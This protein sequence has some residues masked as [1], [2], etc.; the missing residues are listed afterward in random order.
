MKHFTLATAVVAVMAAASTVLVGQPQA[1]AQSS[2]VS[3]IEAID[4][5]AGRSKVVSTPGQLERVA[6]S[7]P[8]IADLKVVN[9]RQILLQ[10]LSPGTTT[11]MVWTKQGQAKSYDVTVGLDARSVERQVR[12]LTGNSHLNVIHNGSAY[13]ISGD[14]EQ[15]AQRDLA[16]KIVA[17]YGAPVVNLVQLPQRREQIQ[18]DV[19]VVELSKAAARDAN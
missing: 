17:S 2:A 9:G 6:I 8:K 11:L 4:L 10:G 16:E 12:A 15:I 13:L 1:L 18:I 3:T 5:M 14:A 19:H 7:N